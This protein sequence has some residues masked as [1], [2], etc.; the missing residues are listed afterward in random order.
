LQTP[1]TVN[2]PLLLRIPGWCTK[3]V[4]RLNGRR[5]KTDAR[6]GA[7]VQIE[8]TW[9][10]GDEIELQFPMNVAIQS[11]PQNGTVSVNHGPLTYSLKIKERY[12]REGGTEDWPA[13]D[14]FPDSPWNYGLVLPE[15]DAA[16]TFKVI[17][18]P[19]P[20]NNQPFEATQSPIELRARGAIIPE[21]TLDPQGL[22]HEVQTGPVY[23]SAKPERITL[24]P[25]GSARLRISAFPVISYGPKANTW[26]MPKPPPVKASHRNENDSLDALLDQ[27]LPSSS[28]D[29][30]IPRFTWWPHRGTSEWIEWTLE[31][32]QTISGFQVYW[33]DDS[34]TGQCRI[35]AA[36]K[37][38]TLQNNQW[39]PVSNP[40]CDPV[41]PN[42]PNTTRFDPVTTTALRIEVQLQPN[43]SGGIL[44][45]NALR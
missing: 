45:I 2:F 42:H 13:W 10:T 36:W 16:K 22:I 11:W 9:K 20:K 25:M 4:I 23:T 27:Q 26:D 30:S 1:K 24:I 8:R 38:L 21:W 28:A 19:W 3:P 40:Q 34:G 7:Y 39:L 41:A 14:I 29:Q 18:H 33:F 6:P 32:R 31:S 17:R 37:I 12:V 35:P 15:K 43:F 5:L 44:E